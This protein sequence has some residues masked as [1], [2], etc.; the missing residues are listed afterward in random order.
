M[1]GLGRAASVAR[2]IHQ[3]ALLL[4]SAVAIRSASSYAEQYA[5]SIEDLDAYWGRMAQKLQWQKPYDTVS[6]HDLAKGQIRWF[7]GGQLN[8]AGR[9]SI[10]THCA[11]C[12]ELCKQPR[13]G[14]SPSSL[15]LCFL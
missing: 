11:V 10:F 7:E 15:R 8:V 9:H 14:R 2:V 12:L 6:N 5:A 3:R 4:R 1:V 13:S